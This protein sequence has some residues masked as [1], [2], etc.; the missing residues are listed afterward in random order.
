[1]SETVTYKVPA[2]HCGHCE[3]AITR[4]VGAV[5]GVDSV[6]VDLETKLV[7]IRGEGLD[8]ERL[9]AAVD[10]AGYDVA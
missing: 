9:R 2:V 4:E 5:E 7:T 8:D 10:E 6:D 3:A 1:M